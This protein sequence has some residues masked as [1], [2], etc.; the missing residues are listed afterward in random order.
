MDKVTYPVKIAAN[1]CRY[2]DFPDEDGSIR[3][4]QQNLA[5]NSFYATRARNGEK[6]TWGIRNPKPWIL[7]DEARYKAALLTQYS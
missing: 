6:I 2:V 3:F 4:M 7:I 1:G 5:K